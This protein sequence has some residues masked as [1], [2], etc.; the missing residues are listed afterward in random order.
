V[1]G[2]P[3]F[4]QHLRSIGLRPE[5]FDSFGG[6]RSHKVSPIEHYDVVGVWPVDAVQ[7]PPQQSLRSRQRKPRASPE[8]QRGLAEQ[9]KTKLQN[10]K[11]YPLMSVEEVAFVFAKSPATIYR[12]LQEEK[13]ASPKVGGRILTRSVRALLRRNRPTSK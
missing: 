10:D 13:L 9:V 4:L 11:A 5:N 3:D 1:S 7:L 2:K 12:W 6:P 8:E